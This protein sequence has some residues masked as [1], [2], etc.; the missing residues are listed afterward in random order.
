MSSS[1]VT[2]T[3]PEVWFLFGLSGC[4][5]S[6]AGDAIASHLGWRVYHADEDIT[7]AM[8][9]A[10]KAARPFTDEMRQAFFEQLQAKIKQLRAASQVPLVVTQGAYKQRHRD[11]LREAIPDIKMLWVRAD[12]ELIR[13]RIQRR[14]QG[15]NLDSAL[16]LLNDFEMPPAD[17]P[18]LDN[19]AD[20]LRLLERFHNLRSS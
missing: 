18:I 2:G 14:A 7:P 11:Y 19:D 5:K 8:R 13:N 17:W 16:A 1:W 6:F 4:G 15:I 9:E 20:E 10:L 12:E 3:A